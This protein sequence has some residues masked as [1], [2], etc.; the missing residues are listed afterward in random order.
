MARIG[1]E[2]FRFAQ[3]LKGYELGDG[4]MMDHLMLPEPETWI[5]RQIAKGRNVLL[6]GTQGFGL[7]LVHGN[8]PFVTS[9]D[10]SAGQLCADC[11]VSPRYLTDVL[12]V[13]RT[14]PI[15]VAGNSGNL[16]EEM[17]WDQI[18]AIVGR[19]VEERTTV[20]KKIRRIGHWDESLF[21]AAIAVNH[22]SAI[23]C[24]FLDYLDP[25]IE[26]RTDEA[27]ISE[28]PK[29]RSFIEYLE[30]MSQVRVSYVGTGGPE[31]SVIER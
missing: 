21:K 10:T 26:G 28:F 3:D 30:V 6:E 9:A 11:G 4:I 1:R 2:N 19:K 7:S 15:R 29:V 27:A 23:A 12:M 5:P 16:Q 8:W 25:G 14:H 20:T 24:T 22:P 17:T 18:S 31:W 13:V